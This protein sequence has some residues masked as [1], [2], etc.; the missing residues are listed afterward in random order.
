[1]KKLCF[2]FLLLFFT[3]SFSEVDTLLN[4]NY[5]QQT[6]TWDCWAS[7]IAMSVNY[8]RFNDP[9]YNVTLS[10]VKQLGPPGWET[11]GVNANDICDIIRYDYSI[12]SYTSTPCTDAHG[13]KNALKDGKPTGIIYI[14]TIR[15]G[16]HVLLCFGYESFFERFHYID[17]SKG[18]DYGE[19]DEMIHNYETTNE[20]EG[21]VQFLN[22]RFNNG[23]Y[24]E[25]GGANTNSEKKKDEDNVLVDTN[26]ITVVNPESCYADKLKKKVYSNPVSF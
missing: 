2:I 20:P 15:N 10:E 5:I 24:N 3:E 1:M 26:E 8:Y 6:E 25:D 22:P 12:E 13:I 9:S 18:R 11:Q 21:S 19:Y 4:V 14:N 16:R 23:T 7:F 17:P